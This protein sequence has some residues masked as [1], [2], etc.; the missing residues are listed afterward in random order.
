MEKGIQVTTDGQ[1]NVLEFEKAPSSYKVISGAVGGYIER[2]SFEEDL[3]MYVN[4]EGK[5]NGSQANPLAQKVWERYYGHTDM[6]MGNV[7]FVGGIDN[8]GWD[9]GLS[10]EQAG[11]LTAIL[12]S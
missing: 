3:A 9:E 1:I 4:E 8:E 11:A 2:V 10:P 7:I 12:Y 6:M 5:F